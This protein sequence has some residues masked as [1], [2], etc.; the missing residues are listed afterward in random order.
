MLLKELRTCMSV[1]VFSGGEDVRF[2][3]SSLL[4]R[5]QTPTPFILQR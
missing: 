3:K 1:K 2:I 4:W 5:C